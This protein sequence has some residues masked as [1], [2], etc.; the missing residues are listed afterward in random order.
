MPSVDGSSAL[1]QHGEEE[2]VRAGGAWGQGKNRSRCQ[3]LNLGGNWC[4]RETGTPRGR[5]IGKGEAVSATLD[6]G[7]DAMLKAISA[8]KGDT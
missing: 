5:R 3:F 7:H 1:F 8:A 2:A 6:A 4:G